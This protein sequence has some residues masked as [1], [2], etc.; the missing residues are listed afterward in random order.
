VLAFVATAAGGCAAELD[1][2][3]RVRAAFAGVRFAVVAART[4]RAGLR[5]EIRRRGW[6]MPIGFDRDGAVFARYGVADCPTL[7]FAYPGG[8]AMRTTVKRLDASALTAAVRA[9]TAGA[10]QRG[11]RPPA[12]GGF[13]G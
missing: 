5:A 6:G 7:V 11:W 1:T 10:R 8:I 13:G 4:D 12:G 9:L 3:Q 2:V